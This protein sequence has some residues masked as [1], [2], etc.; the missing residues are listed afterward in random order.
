MLVNKED[1]MRKLKIWIIEAVFI[2]AVLPLA[3]EQDTRGPNFNRSVVEIERSE[4]LLRNRMGDVFQAPE[5][6]SAFLTVKKEAVDDPEGVRKNRDGYFDISVLQLAEMMLS[7][8]FTLV[9]VHIPYEG[10]L[11][12]T[13]I[14]IP[15]DRITDTENLKK[16]PDKKA[17]IVLYCRSGSM[18]TSAAK[19]LVQLGYTN[20]M[21]LDGGF[22]AWKRAGK[23]LLR[24]G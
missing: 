23:T 11:P 10:E 14:F 15:F 6:V 7:K 1:N 22:N 5:P 18:S 19:N 3:A 17:K 24:T 2:L 13:D 20:I 4:N 16:L 12:Q 8:E 21:E 9:N